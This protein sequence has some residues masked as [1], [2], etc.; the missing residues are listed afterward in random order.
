MNMEYAP[1]AP[2]PCAF[3]YSA[4]QTPLL[5]AASLGALSGAGSLRAT[6]FLGPGGLSTEWFHVHVGSRGAGLRCDAAAA[7][8]A[9]PDAIRDT[10]HC[11]AP[12]IEA[13]R[14]NVSFE[15]RD[16]ARGGA[17]AAD[18]WGQAARGRH[19]RQYAAAAGAPADAP[20]HVTIAPVVLGVSARAS[21]LLGG[22]PLAITGTG[23]STAPG[24]NAVELEATDAAGARALVPCA[25]TAASATRIE[26]V[27]GAAL[28]SSS[29]TLPG[30][31]AGA[32]LLHSIWSNLAVNALVDYAAPSA[33]APT[34]LFLSAD[35]A[36]GALGEGEAGAMNFNELLVGFF[37]PPVSANYTFFVNGDDYCTVW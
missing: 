9:D 34:R 12:P 27:P 17:G 32:G 36:H 25:V 11:A 26:C 8:Q 21:G 22:E 35:A 1:C 23:F 28:N 4:E 19:A 7:L 10:V 15:V 5:A 6:G 2:G 29:A 37:T 31:T 3:T 24:G 20:F 14:Y 18:G 30:A 16:P 13:G 33:P